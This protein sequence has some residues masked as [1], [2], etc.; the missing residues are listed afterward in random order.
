MVCRGLLIVLLTFVG[1]SVSAQT[2]Q[3]KNAG[4]ETWYEFLLKQSNPRNVDYG[5]WI[6]KR[7]E[8][9]LDATVKKPYFWYSASVTAGM[10]FMI[11]AC[12]KLFLDHRRSM[13]IIAEMMAD[14]YSHD[15]LSRQLAAEA[16]EKYNRHIEACN[17]T[18]EASEAGE[19]RPGWGDTQVGRLTAELRLIT[20][21]LQATTQER[22]KL[23]AELRQKSQIVADLSMRINDLSKKGIGARETRVGASVPA[24]TDALGGGARFVGQINRL[25]EELYA[26]RQKNKRLKGA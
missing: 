1:A 14:I 24:A 11:V 17:S 2:P 21:Q 19:T 7:R 23:Q 10:L 26:E 4:R 20:D 18:I 12:V 15:R 16:I 22:N 5:A 25:Q 9:F 8:A 13:R 6:E 3:P